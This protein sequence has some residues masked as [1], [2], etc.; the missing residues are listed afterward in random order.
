M[1]PL[2]LLVSNDAKKRKN[3]VATTPW[4]V[5]LPLPGAFARPDAPTTPADRSGV[6]AKAAKAG[7]V[8]WGVSG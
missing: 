2:G 6:S 4:P 1:A 5:L 8:V 7:E 3:G